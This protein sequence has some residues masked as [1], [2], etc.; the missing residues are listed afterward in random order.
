M[1]TTIV[2]KVYVFQVMFL[3]VTNAPKAADSP[4]IDVFKFSPSGVKTYLVQQDDMFPADP[5][6]V[7]RYTYPFVVPYTLTTGDVVYGEM[8]GMDAEL[9]IRM[10]VEDQVSIGP[11]PSGDYLSGIKARFV[12]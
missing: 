2:G 9:N 11:N 5:V 12:K 3:D 10:V 1:S 4:K 6:E 8:S 7:G